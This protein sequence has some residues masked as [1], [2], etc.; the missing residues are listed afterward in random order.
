MSI[1]TY[2]YIDLLKS[3]IYSI[4]ESPLFSDIIIMRWRDN[5]NTWICSGS[6]FIF[7]VQLV[8]LEMF[9]NPGCLDVCHVLHVLLLYMGVPQCGRPGLQKWRVWRFVKWCQELA[10]LPEI[11]SLEPEID[12]FQEEFVFQ[13]SLFSGSTLVFGGVCSVIIVVSF[14]FVVS[15]VHLI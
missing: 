11:E 3:E 4:L 5:K 1:Y 8:F 9:P 6:G 2:I 13:V 10:Y 14:E 7:V 12:S 15:F